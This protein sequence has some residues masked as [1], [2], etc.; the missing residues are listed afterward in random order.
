MTISAREKYCIGRNTNIVHPIIFSMKI[1]CG[2]EIHQQLD[3]KKLFSNKQ[4]CI[5]E[6]NS[7]DFEVHRNLRAVAGE[8]GEVDAA[9]KI[10]QSKNR[11]F[12]YRGSYAS[13]GMVECDSEPPL[14]INTKALDAALQLS[15]LVNSTRVPI[16]QVMRKTVVDGSNT[17]GFQRTMLVA[18]GGNITTSQGDVGIMGVNIEEDSCRILEQG[19]D[20]AVYH[21]DR[22][23]IPLIEIGTDPDIHSPE[24]AKEVAA[25]LGMYLR[26]LPNC[27]R[28]LG[29]I[30]QDVN[31]S[32]PGGERVE[33]KGAQDLKL[34]PTYVEYE[35]QRQT[36]LLELRD[37]VQDEMLNPFMPTNVTSVFENTT[38]AVLRR[39]L[40]NGG[41][42]HAVKLVGW[43]GRI[44]RELCPGYRVGTELSSRAKRLAGVGGLFHSDE[45]PNYGVTQNEVDTLKQTLDCGVKDAFI[46]VADTEHKVVKALEAVY[47]R[48][49]EMWVGVP[50]EVRK[51][52]MDGT[53]AFLRPMPGAARMYPETDIM[54]INLRDRHVE[55][56]ETV[57][58]RAARYEAMGLS[59]DLALLTS[60]QF[61]ALFERV[62]SETSLKP[63]FIAETLG[64]KLRALSRDGVTVQ[65]S[66]TDF[67]TIFK[68][69]DTE[70]IAKDKVLDAIT[71]MGK[72]TY[73][74]SKLKGMD[75]SE[76]EV[77][78]RQVIEANPG[79]PMGALMGQVMKATKGQAN[80]KKVSELLKKHL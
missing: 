72:G 73:D 29:T 10:E 76:L 47:A 28:G 25:Q 75:D 52:N 40:D 54:T 80:G 56:P 65:L 59:S 8:T 79:A 64:P 11:T 60:K 55:V 70:T 33:I 32:V 18:V 2:I 57:I 30:R 77:I 3:G 13:A 24:Q 4:T 45:M 43:S 41:V 49:Q 67:L 69:I 62:T 74:P 6:D 44:G 61:P 46:M 51:A 78:V 5:S 19:H 42:V 68:D 27:K 23:G 53:T 21:L 16:G 37:E 7:Y 26:S 38:S 17:S 50:K 1:T 14:P 20:R 9:A 35:A 58:E 36:R 39:A 63:A 71:M 31:V 34:I 12:V 22:L 48:L 15:E 66:D